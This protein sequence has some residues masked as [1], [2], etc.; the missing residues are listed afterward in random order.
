M[1]VE[2]FLSGSIF[3]LAILFHRCW[4]RTV[5]PMIFPCLLVFLSVGMASVLGPLR[6]SS[7]AFLK[8]RALEQG[9]IRVSFQSFSSWGSASTEDYWKRPYSLCSESSWPH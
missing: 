3:V 1:S 7:E 6:P 5:C 2:T 9:A 8:A 4:L